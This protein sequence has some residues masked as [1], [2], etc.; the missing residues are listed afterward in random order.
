MCGW[1]SIPE[2][3]GLK[4]GSLRF[5]LILRKKKIIFKPQN[6][7]NKRIRTSVLEI[8]IELY[9]NQAIEVT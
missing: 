8:W 6:L 4:P 3:L 9:I 5:K 2:I 1:I 7:V